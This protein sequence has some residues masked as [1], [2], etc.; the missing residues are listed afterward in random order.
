LCVNENGKFETKREDKNGRMKKNIWNIKTK[1]L[2]RERTKMGIESQT[3]G[4]AIVLNLCD[5]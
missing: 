5:L 4:N 2:K 1:H 3:Q